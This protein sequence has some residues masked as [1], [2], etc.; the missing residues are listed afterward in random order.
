MTPWNNWDDVPYDVVKATLDC[1]QDPQ[2]VYVVEDF[3][4]LVRHL[5]QRITKDY[6]YD[7]PREHNCVI[8]GADACRVAAAIGMD[9]DASY[10]IT[11]DMTWPQILDTVKTAILS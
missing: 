9:R 11:K 4:P 3:P 7:D 5:I 2:G 10:A 8:V 1:L 6:V